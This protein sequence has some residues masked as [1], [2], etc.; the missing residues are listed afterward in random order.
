MNKPCV[1]YMRFNIA[2]DCEV[3]VGFYGEAVT[4]EGIDKFIQVLELSKD[5]FPN[6]EEP[7]LLGLDSSRSSVE[8]NEGVN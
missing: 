3:I 7:K 5:C 6:A 2:R 4:Q 8:T 1:E